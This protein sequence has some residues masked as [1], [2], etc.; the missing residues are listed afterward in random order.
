VVA[1]EASDV[2]TARALLSCGSTTIGR[3]SS[4]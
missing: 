4:P 1:Q 2:E 3:A